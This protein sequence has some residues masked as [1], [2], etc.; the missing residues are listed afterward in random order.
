VDCEE[1]RVCAGDVAL[2][3]ELDVEVDADDSDIAETFQDTTGGY[4]FTGDD[5]PAQ[6]GLRQLSCT[7]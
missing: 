4:G 6:R 2:D 1:T 3:A 5:A 7:F